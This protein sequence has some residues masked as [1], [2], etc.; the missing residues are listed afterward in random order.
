MEGIILEQAKDLLDSD[1][2]KNNNE[3]KDDTLCIRFTR[4]K[5]KCIMLWMLSIIAF[6]LLIDKL[7]DEHDV[8]KLSKKI[9]SIFN[10]KINKT[11]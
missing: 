8:Q 5:Y 1:H 7:F 10:S 3:I 4:K 9:S 6:S 11:E 2:I